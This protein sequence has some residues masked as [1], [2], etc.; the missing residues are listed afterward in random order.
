[1]IVFPGLDAT[2]IVAFHDARVRD[3]EWRP[4][5]QPLSLA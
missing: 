4:R 1:M 2:A 3:A 5:A